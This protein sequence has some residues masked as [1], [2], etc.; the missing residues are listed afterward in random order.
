MQR[1]YRCRRE[2]ESEND[3]VRRDASVPGLCSIGGSATIGPMV[4]DTSQESITG[5]LERILYANEENHYTVASLQPPTH[6]PK[7]YQYMPN[8]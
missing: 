2:T 8:W 5:T 6:L 3:F 7:T 4:A 1:L